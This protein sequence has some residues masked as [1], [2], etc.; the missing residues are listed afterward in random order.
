MSVKIVADSGKFGL[1][2]GRPP[3]SV[4]RFAWA[5]AAFAG[6]GSALDHIEEKIVVTARGVGVLGSVERLIFHAKPALGVDLD[7]AS[8]GV[9][10]KMKV[11]TH[12]LNP[13]YRT[14]PILSMGQ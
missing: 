5:A 9:P 4:G 13:L 8:L 2:L 10:P 6:V 12:R 14:R 7:R 1:E 3:K 11:Q